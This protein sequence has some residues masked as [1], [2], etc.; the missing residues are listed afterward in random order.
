[1][2]PPRL[3]PN[4]N[5]LH[6]D[7]VKGTYAGYIPFDDIYAKEEDEHKWDHPAHKRILVQL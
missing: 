2:N 6:T 3:Q 1:M 4:D 7:P 5:Y